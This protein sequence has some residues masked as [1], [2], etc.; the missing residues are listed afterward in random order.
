MTNVKATN[1]Y[2]HILAT[3]ITNYKNAT[4]TLSHTHG[5][6]VSDWKRLEKI[7]ETSLYEIAILLE[8]PNLPPPGEQLSREH[9]RQCIDFISDQEVKPCRWNPTFPSPT[10]PDA[11][12]H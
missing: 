7:R 11:G 4:Y 2:E 3:K 12:G 1:L 10:M 8:L 9:W 6:T 5:L